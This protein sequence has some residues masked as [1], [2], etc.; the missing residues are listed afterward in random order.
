MDISIKP[1]QEFIQTITNWYNSS[2]EEVDFSKPASAVNS[3]NLWAENITHGHIQ[4]LITDCKYT[5][6]I[7]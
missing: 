6:I 2:F 3:I 4:Q 1:K 5:R 7:F